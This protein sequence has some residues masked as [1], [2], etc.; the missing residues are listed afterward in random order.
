VNNIWRTVYSAEAIK[1]VW[2]LFLTAG[3]ILLLWGFSL[4]FT[5]ISSI[6]STFL[7]GI[8]LV[9]FVTAIVKYSSQRVET[10]PDGVLIINTW[11][12]EFVPWEMV[13]NI[14]VAYKDVVSRYADGEIRPKPQ[15]WGRLV[16]NDNSLI[17]FDL[18][19][20]PQRIVEII[21]VL[22]NNRKVCLD[23]IH[24]DIISILSD[25][26]KYHDNIFS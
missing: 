16:A 11:N 12:K 22:K 18:V 25:G 9:I 10:H 3:P 20:G 8:F 2:I 6:F 1:T 14:C 7:F 21:L 15:V 26:K 4:F 13:D 24:R 5:P 23:A 17:L 19:R